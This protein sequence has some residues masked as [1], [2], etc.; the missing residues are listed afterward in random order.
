[1]GSQWTGMGTSLMKLPIF[2]ES[3]Q[4]SNSILKEFGIDLIKIIT[5]SDHQI[6]N[7]TVNSFVGIT[8]IEVNISFYQQYLTNVFIYLK[9][10]SDRII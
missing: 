1:M 8:A 5:N 3:I 6:L 7:N 10:T 2:N 4:K 9:F